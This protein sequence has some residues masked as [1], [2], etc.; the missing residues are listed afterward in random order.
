[1]TLVTRSA[2]SRSFL[3]VISQGHVKV[4]SQG[5]ISRTYVKV[6]SQGH[7]SRTYVKVI[8]EGHVSRSYFKVI[9]TY[10]SRSRPI[11]LSIIPLPVTIEA[12]ENHLITTAA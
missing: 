4:I 8:S 1:M 6:I 2:C 5:H 3:K 7:I 12:D 9:S 11:S 10:T